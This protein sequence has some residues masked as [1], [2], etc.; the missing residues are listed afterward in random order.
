MLKILSNFMGWGGELRIIEA[1]LVLGVYTP[2]GMS[3]SLSLLNI[4]HLYLCTYLRTSPEMHG[5]FSSEAIL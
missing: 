2:F 4:I 3:L 1:M 5:K